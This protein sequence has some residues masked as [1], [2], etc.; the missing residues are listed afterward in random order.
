MQPDKTARKWSGPYGRGWV[1][2]LGANR[3]SALPAFSPACQGGI[4][5]HA[6]AFERVLRTCAS[7]GV[8][9]ED[10]A[11]RF[12]PTEISDVLTSD[13]PASVKNTLELF[14]GPIAR[15][16]SE[17]P[18]SVKTSRPQVSRV[19]NISRGAGFALTLR[20]GTSAYTGIP[21]RHNSYAMAWRV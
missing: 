1:R 9:T 5:A 19:A 15:V 13:S 7:V 17:L 20:S 2:R 16:G 6:S 11:G 14:V 3:R 18:E 10:S 4:E 8:F 12:G 21:N